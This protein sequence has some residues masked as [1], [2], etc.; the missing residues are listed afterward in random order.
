MKK[1]VKKKK[2]TKKVTSKKNNEIRIITFRFI[3]TVVLW[4]ILVVWILFCMY[5]Y[6]SALNEQMPLYCLKEEKIIYEDGIVE[7]CT[8]FGYKVYNYK[9][10][11]Y[12]AIEFGPFW[13]KDS[14]NNEK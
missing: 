13:I 11:S 3:I 4:I 10:K 5:D 9:R 14:S 1:E 8:S 2:T 7:S 12:R 6:N